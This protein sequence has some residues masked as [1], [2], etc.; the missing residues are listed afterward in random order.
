MGTSV[1]PQSYVELLSPE[2][3][4]AAPLCCGPYESVQTV[5]GQLSVLETRGGMSQ[6]ITLAVQGHEGWH[7]H[8]GPGAF[9][10]VWESVRFSDHGE[11]GATREGCPGG[12]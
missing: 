7:V 3:P 8:D 6:R 5:G 2:V 12:E 4:G 10:R 11:P 9:V 1:K